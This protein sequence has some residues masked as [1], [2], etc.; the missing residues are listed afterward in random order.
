MK[1]LIATLAL[2]VSTSAFAS[3]SRQLLCDG[4]LSLLIN[5]SQ[6]SLHVADAGDNQELKKATLG[7]FEQKRNGP[8]TYQMSGTVVFKG[9]VREIS[10]KT[11]F[12]PGQLN[13]AE[14]SLDGEETTL[15]CQPLTLPDQN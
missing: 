14:V 8:D 1:A 11:V 4:D 3:E 7:Y 5:P 12:R 15:T 10:V 13:T 2:L 6:K 9:E